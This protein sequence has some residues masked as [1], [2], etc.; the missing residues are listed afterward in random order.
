M[1]APDVEQGSAVWRAWARGHRMVISV[2]THTLLFVLS[3]FL[4]FCLAYNFKNFDRWFSEFFLPLLPIVVIIKLLVFVLSG[5][6][7]GWWRYVGL[8]DVFSVSTAAWWSCVLVMVLYYGLAIAPSLGVPIDPFAGEDF[9]DSV[10]L[11]DL[12]GTVALVCGARIAVR[13]YHEEVRPVADGAAP[14]LLILGAGNAAENAVREILRMPILQYRIVGFLDDDLAKHGARIHGIEILGEIADVKEICDEHKVDEILIAMP[15]ASRQ[16]IRRV[17]ELC[18]DTNLRFKTLPAMADLIAGKATVSQIRDV[19]INDLLGRAPVKLDEDVIGAFLKDR[20]V[21]VTGAG[22]SIGSEMC[23][24]VARFGP[25]RMLLVEKSENLL[26]EVE[27][28]LRGSFPDLDFVPLIADIADEGRM[29]SL[30]SRERPSAVFH[31]AAHKHVPMMEYNPGEAIKNNV[32]G[33]QVIADAAAR[34]GCEKFVMISTDK[35]VN[36]TS[37]MGASKR[38]AEMYIQGLNERAQTHFVTVRFGNVL[39]SSGSVVPIFKQQIARGGPVTVTHPDMVRFFMTIPEAAQLVLQA[40]SMGK[41]GEIFVLDMGEPVKIVD[42]ARDLITLSGLKPGEDIEITF[43]G[44][45]PGEKLYEELST[46]GEDI[47]QTAHPKI[48]IWRNRPVNLEELN[49]WVTD[50]LSRANQFS[51]EELRRH[52]KTIVPEFYVEEPKT[53]IQPK[54]VKATNA[55]AAANTTSPTTAATS[56]A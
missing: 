34:N 19:D 1:E 56:T 40:A 30:F 46:E 55:A 26:F 41:G 13:L 43:S 51:R 3:W 49:A 9:P 15:S 18:K 27:R 35:A 21:M 7:R 14:L 36:P 22:G 5:Q 47:S 23:R 50:T 39:G 38:V 6:H 33:T 28:E 10:F 37:I 12:A 52:I 29:N 24:Q 53:V 8:R 20:T 11:L 45:R 31:A 25:H 32:R 2:A 54:T 16:Q 44:I 42:L 4:A 48:G 17:V